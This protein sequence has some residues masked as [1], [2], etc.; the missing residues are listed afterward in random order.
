MRIRSFILGVAVIA[1]VP[2]GVALAQA[3]PAPAVPVAPVV[4]AV[5]ANT[6]NRPPFV[7]PFMRGGTSIDSNQEPMLDRAVA[8]AQ[9]NRN[10]GVVVTGIADARGSDSNRATRARNMATAV[11]NYLRDRGIPESRSRTAAEGDA[12]P[13]AVNRVEITFVPMR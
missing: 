1:A 7:V 4:P 6:A 11:R 12:S 9:S 10:M 13:T 8:Y 5:P 3:A 2:A